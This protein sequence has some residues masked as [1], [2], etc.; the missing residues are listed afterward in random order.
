MHVAVSDGDI[1]SQVW[2]ILLTISVLQGIGA[3]GLKG[4]RKGYISLRLWDTSPGLR[5]LRKSSWRKFIVKLEKL[6]VLC[7]D[8][9]LANN[10]DSETSINVYCWSNGQP[11]PHPLHTHGD[12]ILGWV[13]NCSH[14][15]A[16]ENNICSFQVT[17]YSVES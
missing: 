12:S 3:E 14:M 13:G 17:L 11:D 2:S 6:I 9:Y 8:A 1:F 5:R 15:F 7:R 10:V 4:L 16:L